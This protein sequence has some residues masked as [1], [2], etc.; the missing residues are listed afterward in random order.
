MIIRRLASSQQ[1]ISQPEHAALAARLMSHWQVNH[2]PESSR[3]TS[4]LYATRQHDNGWAEIDEDLVVDGATG[5]LLD[6]VALPDALKRDTA[7]RGIERLA[8]DPY[9][10]ALVAQHRL[11]VY[12][13][14]AEQPDWLTFF[15]SV[16]AARDTYLRAAGPVSLDE[17]LRDYRFVRAGD[18][19]SLA[20]CN[21]WTDVDSD[22]CGYAMRL[23]GTSLVV[24]PDPFEGRTIAIEIDAR[25]IDHQSFASAED[26]RRVVASARVVTLRGRVSGHAELP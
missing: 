22:G 21:N 20:F 16:T 15:A 19:A 14:Y 11:H 13:R 7:W 1:L 23:Q 25:E 12:R 17:L 24:T 18:L 3:K 26:A 5:Q 6:F 9:A 2:F 10:A 4:I 8:S